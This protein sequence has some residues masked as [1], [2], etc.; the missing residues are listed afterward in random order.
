MERHA[1][2]V[3]RERLQD[4]L[5]WLHHQISYHKDRGNLPLLEENFNWVASN[6]NHDLKLS[7][8]EKIE[9]LQEFAES[10]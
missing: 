5:K 9:Y 3:V 2:G 10:A 4:Q 7:H 6:F 1:K 8:A